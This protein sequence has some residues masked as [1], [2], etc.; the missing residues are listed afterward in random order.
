MTE[1]IMSFKRL[2]ISNKGITM[3]VIQAADTLSEAL[4]QELDHYKR[5]KRIPAEILIQGEEED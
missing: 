3:D 2:S 5:I 1:K 4:I